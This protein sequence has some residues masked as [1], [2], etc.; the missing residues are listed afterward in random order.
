MGQYILRKLQVCGSEINTNRFSSL[1]I[2]SIVY[3]ASYRL[4]SLN[5]KFA[6]TKIAKPQSRTEVKQYYS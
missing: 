5:L 4:G 2:Q 1:S 3:N 6:Y